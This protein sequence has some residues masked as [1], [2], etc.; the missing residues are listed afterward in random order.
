MLSF[1]LLDIFFI[2]ILNIFP[3]LDF[4]FWNSLSHSASPCLFEGAF[5]PTHPPTPV[6]P[7]WHSP[8]LEHQTPS[9]LM[10]P[11]TTDV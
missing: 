5:P 10:A 8:T 9:G 6:F 4:P 2:Y 1:F 11:P 3:F 7:P